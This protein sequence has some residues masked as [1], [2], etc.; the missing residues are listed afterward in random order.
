M[1]S[2][3]VRPP[4][5]A[6]WL[7]KLFTL[8]RQ[9]DSIGGDLLEEFS[10]LVSKSGVVSARR[11]YWLQSIRTSFHLIGAAFRSSPWQ[12]VLA[13]VAGY[14]LGGVLYWSTEKAISTIHS[15]YQV[16]AH[17]DAYSFWLIYGLFIERLIIPMLAG[18]FVAAVAKGKETVATMTLALFMGASSG[19]GLI[20][21]LRM[22]HIS[23][24]LWS[25]THSSFL[26]SPLVTTFISPVLFVIGGVI[27]REIR[28]AAAC[29]PYGA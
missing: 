23:N 9:T 5:V 6:V 22:V 1:M 18:C 28:F 25:I 8:D 10:G 4:V 14:A 17:I 26:L 24:F 27:V 12:I 19:V 7:L 20:H 13:V 15:K 2:S 16:Y 21:L 3:N 11:W 29:R